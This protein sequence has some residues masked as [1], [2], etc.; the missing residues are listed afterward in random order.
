MRVLLDTHLLLWALGSPSR[1]SAGTRKR[2]E[3][4]EVFVSAAEVV[5]LPALHKDHF[6]R[7]LVAQATVEPMIVLT[8]ED[9]LRGYGSF[10]HV[11]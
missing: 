8:N 3:T 6:D 5:A 10:V 7:M 4:A 9:E 1:L 2:I 11:V